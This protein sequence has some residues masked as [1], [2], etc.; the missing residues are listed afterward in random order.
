M[1]LRR[2]ADPAVGDQIRARRLLRGWSVRYAASRAGVSHATWSRIERG[3]QTADNR[4]MLAGIAG[5]LECA[6][7]DLAGAGVPAPDRATAAARAGVLGLRRALVDIDLTEP[8]A[9]PAPSM[10]ELRRSAA[11][12]DALHQACDYAGAARLLPDLLRD[13]HTETAGPD[14]L[15]ALRLLCDAT[16]IASTVLR[17]LGHP[18][19]A[20][21]GAERCRDA[22]D[23]TGDPVLRGHAAYALA[24]AAV[25]CGSYQRGQTLA[26]R[27]VDDLSGH[28]SRPGGPEVLGSLHLVAALA[29]R[30]RQRLDDSMDWLTEAARMARRTGETNV[31]GMFFGPTNVDIWRMSIEADDG[32]PLRVVEIARRTDP[33]AIPA[34]VRQVFYYADTA[35]ALTRIGGRDR[36]AIRFLLTAERIAPQ[37]VRTSAELAETIRTLLDRSRRQ[38]GGAE[39]RALYERM[40][41]N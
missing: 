18:A 19:D 1:T 12:A 39:V 10:S 2:S 27:A 22:A 14:H 4:F 17:S 29:S 40:Q 16:H 30:C 7:A 15:E 5:A 20:W 9:G 3:L 38:A 13:L 11:L 32:D 36:E 41:A 33:A 25:A 6:P 35:R 34:G 8:P 31:M 28:L 26:E 23:A 24:R 37:H 21:L